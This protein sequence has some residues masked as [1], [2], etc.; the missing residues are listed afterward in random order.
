MTQATQFSEQIKLLASKSEAIIQELNEVNEVNAAA[1]ETIDDLTEVLKK[2]KE[3]RSEQAE[4]ILSIK[5][6]EARLLQVLFVEENGNSKGNDD[7]VSVSL[8][9]IAKKLAQI[10]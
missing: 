7:Q 9:N 5:I 4:L 10:L 8:P 2:S 3:L 6:N 1:E